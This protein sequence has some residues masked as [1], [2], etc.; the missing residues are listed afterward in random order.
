MSPHITPLLSSEIILLNVFVINKISHSWIFWM[1]FTLSHFHSNYF[2]HVPNWTDHSSSSSDHFYF[3]TDLLFYFSN[4][5]LCPNFDQGTT[6]S[7]IQW[8][9]HNLFWVYIC[10]KKHFETFLLDFSK[11]FKNITESNKNLE[12]SELESL[13]TYRGLFATTRQ[14]GRFS[15]APRHAPHVFTSQDPDISAD[16]DH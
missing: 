9:A 7:E 4:P 10:I 8:L 14:V 3:S 6:M 15:E 1:F 16:H 12:L 2:A 13:D 5:T 11:C